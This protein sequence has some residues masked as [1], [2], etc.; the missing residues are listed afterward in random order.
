MKNDARKEPFSSVLR[1]SDPSDRKEWIKDGEE[2][3]KLDRGAQSDV[4]PFAAERKKRKESERERSEMM[5]CA[6]PVLFCS[7]FYSF[8]AKMKKK[9]MRKEKDK[10]R[11]LD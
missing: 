4:T 8:S 3:A 5:K 6:F 11:A 10:R 7:L 1:S 9:K 2:T